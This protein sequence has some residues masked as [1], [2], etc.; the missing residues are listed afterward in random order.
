MHEVDYSFEDP[1]AS[2]SDEDSKVEAA[3]MFYSADGMLSPL[4]SRQMRRRATH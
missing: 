2:D 4:S 1:D 3:N